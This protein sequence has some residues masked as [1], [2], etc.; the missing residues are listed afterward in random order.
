M[1]R[2]VKYVQDLSQY[3]GGKLVQRVDLKR[4]KFVKHVPNSKMYAKLAFS[5]Y[6]MV[7]Q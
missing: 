1:D 3:L 7:Y 2:N 4:Q 5:T 6:N